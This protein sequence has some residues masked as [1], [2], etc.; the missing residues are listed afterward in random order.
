MKDVEEDQTKW[1]KNEA[2]LDIKRWIHQW[3]M[4]E[5]EKFG[6]LFDGTVE[7]N[8]SEAPLES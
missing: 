2:G 6:D 3:G 5:D 7:E 1:M 8:K 4:K